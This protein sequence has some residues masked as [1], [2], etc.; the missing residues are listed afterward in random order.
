MSDKKVYVKSVVDDDRYDLMM[1]EREA[2]YEPE[3]EEAENDN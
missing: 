3:Y 2:D 1:E